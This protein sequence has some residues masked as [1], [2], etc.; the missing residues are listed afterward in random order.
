MAQWLR[1][2]TALSKDPSL[3]PST[4]IKLLPITCNSISTGYDAL[5][6]NCG[7]PYRTHAQN[8]E[9]KSLQ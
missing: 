1:E 5:I 8:N 4:H 7:T 3:I 2:F 6:W 9:N